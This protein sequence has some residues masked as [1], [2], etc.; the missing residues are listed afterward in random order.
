MNEIYRQTGDVTP[1]SSAITHQGVKEMERSEEHPQEPTDHFPS[2]AS[3]AVYNIGG[4]MIGSAIQSNSPGAAQNVHVGDIA[5]NAAA[6][7]RIRTFLD[8]YNAK[9]SALHHEQGE[10]ALAEIASDIATMRAQLASPKPKPKPKFIRDSLSSIKAVLEDGVG[11]IV[12]N[13]LLA[14]LAAIHI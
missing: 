1:M 9:L 11:G 2:R 13:G 10:E 8:E 5:I 3:M 14:L 6:R 7:E 12:T 4:E